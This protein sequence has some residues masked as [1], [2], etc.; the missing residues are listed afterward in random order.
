[1]AAPDR[2]K[3][4]LEVLCAG[5]IV[6]CALALRMCVYEKWHNQPHS[7]LARGTDSTLVMKIDSV[8]RAAD[9]RQNEKKKADSLKKTKKDKK[10]PASRDFLGEPVSSGN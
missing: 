3:L 1:M 7:S 10:R 6:G 4:I 2:K 9:L 5:L 8:E